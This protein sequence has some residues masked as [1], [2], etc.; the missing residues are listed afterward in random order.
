[1]G[2]ADEVNLMRAKQE[3]EEEEYDD[4]VAAADSFDPSEDELVLHFLRPQLR[5]FP[6]RVSGAVVEADPCSAAPWDLLARYGLRDVGHFFAA[7]GRTRPSVRR[8]VGG[9][10]WMR[11]AVRSGRSVSELGLVVRWSRAKFCFYMRQRSTGWVM[12]EYEI[13]D[14]RCYRRDDEG[15]EDDYW[16]LCR[17]RKSSKT[18]AI[19]MP[20]TSMGNTSLMRK[21]MLAAGCPVGV[22]AER[23]LLF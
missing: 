22:E 5:G 2:M 14:P 3:E 1:M 21:R 19:V 12:E 11:S 13:T 6:P 10:A 8:S 4:C 16:V 18:A 9:G 20:S 23:F 17:V 7:R 15:Q